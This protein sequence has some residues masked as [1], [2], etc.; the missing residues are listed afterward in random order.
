MNS[1]LALGTVQFGLPYGVASSGNGVA[2]DDV[3]AILSA[4]WKIGID[5]LDTAILYGKCEQLLGKIGI[6]QWHVITKLPDIPEA[7]QDVTSWV[8][9]CVMGSLKRLGV[10]KLYGLLLHNSQQLLSSQG[11]ALYQALLAIQGQGRV[12]K[13]G[14]SI[15]GPDELDIIWPSY[16]FDLV[17]APLNILDRRL[18][19]SGWLARLHQA[20]AEVHVRSVFLQGL[21]LMDAANRHEKFNR[22]QSL[23]DDWHCWLKNQALTPIEACLGI[24]ISQ[25]E[26]NRVVVGVDSL[27]QLQEIIECAKNAVTIAPEFLMSNDLDLINPSRWSS[28]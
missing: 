19:S 26:V 14:I 18:V 21:L 5:T 20:G 22:W 6:D 28:F 13:I 10:S 23:W 4:A 12:E 9:D 15:Y 25:P 24:A 16:Q 27:D 1:R 3:D 8:E 2:D 17:Q 7:C 11:K